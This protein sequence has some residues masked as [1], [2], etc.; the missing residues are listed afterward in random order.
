MP[1]IIID[2]DGREVTLYRFAKIHDNYIDVIIEAVTDPDGYL[3]D[4]IPAEDHWGAGWVSSDGN[5][6]FEPP[7]PPAGPRI[8]THLQYM[9]R[10]TMTEL[11]NIY[12]AAKSVV[13]VEIWLDK[14][15]MATDVNLDD[16][17]TIAGLQAME[18]ANLLEPGRAATILM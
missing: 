10:F 4:F 12:T 15:K 17:V 18:E 1:R 5:I 9:N 13:D 3:G 2:E 16:P 6:T 8:L 7:P 14:F 11:R